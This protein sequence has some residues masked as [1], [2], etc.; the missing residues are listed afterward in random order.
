MLRLSTEFSTFSTLRIKRQ[1]LNTQFNSLL[2]AE[3]VF[4][5][6]FQA[7]YMHILKYYT[8]YPFF[9]RQTSLNMKFLSV[10]VDLSENMCYN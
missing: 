9:S 10:V 1:C 6:S 3:Q 8:Y 7:R 5:F 2:K 4:I